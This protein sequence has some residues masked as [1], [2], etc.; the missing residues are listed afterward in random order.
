M[1]ISHINNGLH[2]FALLLYFHQILTAIN[3]EE[4]PIIFVSYI[5]DQY[6]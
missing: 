1:I 2:V 6:C 4:V 3:K 5:V